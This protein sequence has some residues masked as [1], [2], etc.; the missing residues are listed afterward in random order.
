MSIDK[1]PGLCRPLKAGQLRS[2][3]G[4]GGLTVVDASLL[5]FWPNAGRC[6]VHQ[7]AWAALTLCIGQ[8]SRRLGQQP[9][10]PKLADDLLGV[11]WRR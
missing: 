1:P 3:R 7:L 8:V 6:G 4:H 9:A 11:W 2:D 5:A 10:S